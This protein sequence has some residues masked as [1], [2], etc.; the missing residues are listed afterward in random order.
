MPD[1]TRYKSVTQLNVKTLHFPINVGSI[2]KMAMDA[3]IFLEK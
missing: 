1:F 2:N 3:I